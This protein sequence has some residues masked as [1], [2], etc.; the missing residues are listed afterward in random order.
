MT[1]G[2]TMLGLCVAVAAAMPAQAS[3]LGETLTFQRLY[4]TVD[5]DFGPPFAPQ[6]V[7]VVAGDADNTRWLDDYLTVAPEAAQITF[8]FA[9]GSEMI[10]NGDVFDGYA[11]SGFS[12]A[13]AVSIGL[14]TTGM[15]GMLTVDG[16]TVYLSLDGVH[17]PG[18]IVLDFA[19]PVPEPA[20]WAL[21]A[22]GLAAVSARRRLR[23]H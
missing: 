18:Q 20:A 11:I 10:G 2:K 7:T 21:M 22:L 13:P 19:T 17:S 9:R 14:N 4:P 15:A 5:I 1:L 23:P 3:L 8:S 16:D 12:V 6:T